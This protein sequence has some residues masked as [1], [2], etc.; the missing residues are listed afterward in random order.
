MSYITLRDSPTKLK[1]MTSSVLISI[2]RK[3]REGFLTHA[4]SN[5]CNQNRLA[6]IKKEKNMQN[7]N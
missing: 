3:R 6:S 2:P 1:V 4:K 7:A 5:Y